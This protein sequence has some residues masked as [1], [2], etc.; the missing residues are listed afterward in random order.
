MPGADEDAVGVR[1]VADPAPLPQV[2]AVHALNVGAAGVEVLG[3]V[4]LA[5]EVVHEPLK[6]LVVAGA[7]GRVRVVRAVERSVEVEGRLVPGRD[8][9]VGAGALLVR[10][11]GRVGR[12][13]D[14]DLDGR[15]DVQALGREGDV[16]GHVVRVLGREVVEPAAE[17]AQGLGALAQGD[18]PLVDELGVEAVHQQGL[19]AVLHGLSGGAVL[20]AVL[21]AEDEP[22]HPRE[23]PREVL[24]Q[25][26][27]VVV[28]VVA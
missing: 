26:E 28:D 13:A 23:S 6:G 8:V 16:V 19:V 11:E 27:E 14:A 9:Q 1:L 21:H 5:A 22:L 15:V 10:V 20:E 7:A 2:V 12:V 18:G 17:A 25:V 4:G 24:G 3:P